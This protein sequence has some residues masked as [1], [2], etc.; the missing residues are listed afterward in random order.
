LHSGVCFGRYF[1]QNH[2]SVYNHADSTNLVLEGQLK[3]TIIKGIDNYE[4]LGFDEK[5][6]SEMNGLKENKNPNEEP[7]MDIIADS[8]FLFDGTIMLVDIKNFTIK[9]I[10]YTDPGEMD[11]YKIDR[12]K[13]QKIIYKKG[14]VEIINTIE[15][16]IPD[17][18][19]WRNILVTEN[20]GEVEDYTKVGK[21]KAESGNYKEGIENDALERSAIIIIKKRA[22]KLDAD[23]ILITDKNI[24]RGYGEPPVM[25]MKGIAYKID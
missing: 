5:N 3:D 11:M 21:V 6:R 13:V 10:C 4:V 1:A 12:R 16:D 9:D 23:I 8:M 14:M 18:K 2:D 17:S 25:I 19:D 7:E 24:Y 15:K 20:P 22:A